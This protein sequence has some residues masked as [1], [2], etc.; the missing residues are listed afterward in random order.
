MNKMN[1]ST[2]E[3]VMEC[4]VDCVSES[5]LLD[6]IEIILVGLAALVA[7]VAWGY[8]KY[9][10]L[11]A[12]GSISLDEII[13]SIDEVKEKVAEAED[14]IDDVTEAAE[15]VKSKATKKK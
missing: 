13:D 1:N 10:S 11:S 4:V 5:S 6:E 2:N 7:L 9:K 8:R 12:D 15:N 14:V 3:T